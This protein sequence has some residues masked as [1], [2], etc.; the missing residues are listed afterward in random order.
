MKYL[1]TFIVSIAFCYSLDAQGLKNHTDFFEQANQEYVNW[2]DATH[3]SEIIAFS[4]M[5]IQQDKIILHLKS[6]YESDDSLKIAWRNAE[7]FYAKEYN[8][9]I[10]DK[11]FDTFTFLLDLSPEEAEIHISGNQFSTNRIKIFF[12]DGEVGTQ[13]NLP[14]VMVGDNFEISIDNLDFPQTLRK[15]SL[16]DGLKV[17]DVR[18]KLGDFLQEYYKKEGTYFYHAHVDT[19]KTY[20]NSLVYIVTCLDKQIIEEISY[21]EKIKIAVNVFIED[22]KVNVAYDITGKYASGW[23][24]PGR[25]E[26]LYKSVEVKYADQLKDYAHHIGKL[27]EENLH[28]ENTISKY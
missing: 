26:G 11:L 5:D 3:L 14:D 7:L 21:Y 12:Y 16:G 4:H 28:K 9:L 17:T 15:C 18:R 6:Q 20:R 13:G 23:S 8:S 2:L 25:R 22:N 1:I 19:T 27:L 10:T 24:C